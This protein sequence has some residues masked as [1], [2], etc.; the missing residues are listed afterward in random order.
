MTADRVQ[1]RSFT[2]L[3][4]VN[5]ISSPKKDMVRAAAEEAPEA[6]NSV[7]RSFY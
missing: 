3:W 4:Y 1:T 2:G 6:L 7:E 5:I